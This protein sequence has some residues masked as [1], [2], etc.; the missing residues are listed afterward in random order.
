M[1]PEVYIESIGKYLSGNINPAEEAALMQWVRAAEANKKFFDE[2]VQLWNLSEDYVEPVFEADIQTAWHSLEQKIGHLEQGDKPSA[3]GNISRLGFFK[4]SWR[5]AAAILLLIG[6]SYWAF[7]GGNDQEA[8]NQ[9]VEEVTGQG[10]QRQLMLPDS[11]TV[12]LNENSSLAYATDFEERKVMLSGEAFFEVTKRAGKKFT[13]YTNETATTVLGTSFNVRA[14]PE[15]AKV[16]VTV[17]TGKVALSKKAKAEASTEVEGQLELE[18]GQSGVYD[19]SEGELDIAVVP[20]ANAWKTKELSFDNIQLAYLAE[21]LERYFDVKITF[22]D[23]QLMNCRY[24]GRFPNPTLEEVI[25]A[26]EFTM[27]LKIEE[28]SG[29]YLITGDAAQCE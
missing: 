13:I 19:K 4:R 27:D 17:S 15:E 29:Q 26:L 8:S 25:T 11:S 24:L 7:N 2:M 1:K 20:N 9:L 14:Y 23:D 12:V 21:S 10:E 18:A 3:G 16:E 22:E 5:Y 28:K 6:V